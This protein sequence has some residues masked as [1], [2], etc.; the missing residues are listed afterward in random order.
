LTGDPD[1]SVKIIRRADLD[2]YND[3]FQ[4]VAMMYNKYDGYFYLAMGWNSSWGG[5]KVTWWRL[6]F[7]TS[8]V[9]GIP[10]NSGLGT[11][12]IQILNDTTFVNSYI[13]DT[14]RGTG[15][16]TGLIT[17]Y[18]D[19]WQGRAQSPKSIA[20]A[21]AGGAKRDGPCNALQ[22]GRFLRFLCS[23]FTRPNSMR[24]RSTTSRVRCR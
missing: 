15:V 2:G 21:N 24:A 3:K 16:S 5:I 7:E 13:S 4:H 8:N 17:D 19:V 23:L 18:F 1:Q 12:E 14:M 22:I 9:Y 20:P 11:Y 10:Y 6:K